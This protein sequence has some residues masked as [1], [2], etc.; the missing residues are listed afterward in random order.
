VYAKNGQVR[1]LLG[2]YLYAGLPVFAIAAVAALA[3]VL[4]LARRWWPTMTSDAVTAAGTAATAIVCAAMVRR[5]IHGFYGTRS[6]SEWLDRMGR[7]SALGRPGP[8]LVVLAVV[9][10]AAVVAAGYGVWSRTRAAYAPG[11]AARYASA[12]P[13]PINP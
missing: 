4:A 2:R 9:W 11:D 5:A 6:P 7:V 1:G 3:S 13:R 12:Q 10:V 8:A